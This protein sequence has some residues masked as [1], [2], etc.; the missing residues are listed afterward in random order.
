MNDRPTQNNPEATPLVLPIHAQVDLADLNHL[1]ELLV[2]LYPDTP[3]DR[4]ND[5][6]Y[7]ALLGRVRELCEKLNAI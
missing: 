2:D 7:L 6:K 1:T 3:E 5:D 4:R